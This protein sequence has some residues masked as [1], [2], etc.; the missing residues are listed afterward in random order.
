MKA[1]KLQDIF[2]ILCYIFVQIAVEPVVSILSYE[3]KNFLKIKQDPTT[4]QLASSYR[5]KKHVSD[6][7]SNDTTPRENTM[8]N[9]FRT[10]RNTPVG[11]SRN[12]S[13]N[14]NNNAHDKPISQYKKWQVG[15][16]SRKQYEIINMLWRK[17]KI[18]VDV[19]STTSTHLHRRSNG[20]ERI[21]DSVP[22]YR[23]PLVRVPPRPSV[24]S[25]TPSFIEFYYLDESDDRL[26]DFPSKKLVQVPNRSREQQLR[27]ENREF[28]LANSH[29]FSFRIDDNAY[30]QTKT[31]TATRF[32]QPTNKMRRR[33][34][35]T[36]DSALT[37]FESLNSLTPSYKF[38]RLQRPHVKS[39]NLIAP[40]SSR[41]IKMNVTVNTSTTTIANPLVTINNGT[42]TNGFDNE[43][44]P[45]TTEDYMTESEN[46]TSSHNKTLLNTTAVEVTTAYDKIKFFEMYD[47]HTSFPYYDENRRLMDVDNIDMLKKGNI[48]ERKTLLEHVDQDISKENSQPHKS[49]HSKKHIVETFKNDVNLQSDIN[50]I[51]VQNKTMKPEILNDSNTNTNNISSVTKQDMKQM[52]LS[53][54]KVSD[55]L[56]YKRSK[57]VEWTQYPFV[58]AYVYEPS[59]VHCDAAGISPHWLITSG[60]CL[61]RHHKKPGGEGRS[62]FVTY[63]GDSWWTPERV[64]YVKYSLVHP[65]F[66]PRD[67]TRRHLYNIGLIQV[68]TSM[69][70]ACSA[71][72][73]IS[74]MSHQF[75]ADDEGSVANAVGWGLDRFDTRYSSNDLPKSPLMSYENEVFSGSCPGNVGYSKA[76]RLAEEGGVKNVYCLALPPYAGEDTDPIH[77]G[78][79]LVGGKL[80]ALYLQEERRPWGDQSA[81]YTGIWRLVPWVLDVARE[82]DDV[83]AF[84]LDM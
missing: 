32:S 54:S 23:S 60:S 81:Q 20:S 38:S 84:T 76:K 39:D 67:K 16:V 1:A 58:A 18:F 21:L 25:T 7:H 57:H 6:R 14:K 65:R 5:N 50:S 75:V 49:K 17:T 69:S 62:A 31:H 51:P 42:I 63:C 45:L 8:M 83:D 33:K 22:V 24:S 11:T 26:K 2:L 27:N 70:S 46:L 55:S 13:Q 48:N 47:R 4:Y 77:G 29:L 43:T 82:N 71:W 15:R 36:H 73:S 61:S 40:K 41:E 74:M 56:E 37:G 72:S 19:E 12:Y 64:A 80:V 53:Q 10:S 9:A 34:T 78:L 35:R 52:L 30:K 44:C 59:Q 68:V 28:V 66:N 79:L 3:N